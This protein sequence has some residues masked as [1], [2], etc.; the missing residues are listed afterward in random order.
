[1]TPED[2]E[3][4]LQKILNRIPAEWGKWIDVRPGWYPIVVELDRRL[5]EIDSAY[6]VHQVKQKL[7]GLRYYC[8]IDADPRAMALIANAEGQ[9]EVTCEECGALGK[10][11]TGRRGWI[12]V[13]CPSC[14]AKP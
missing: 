9:C 12:A 3:L 11:V 14:A 2:V 13:L 8:S 6:E 7:G 1:M 4:G 10:R 5:A